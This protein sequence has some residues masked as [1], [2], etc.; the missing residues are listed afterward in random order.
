[1]AGIYLMLLGPAGALRKAL[2]LPGTI[3]DELLVCKWGRTE[4]IDMRMQKHQRYYGGLRGAALELVYFAPVDPR[5]QAAAEKDAKESLCSAG[6][7]MDFVKLHGETKREL[8]AL[9]EHNLKQLVGAHFRRIGV[10]YAGCLREL[11]LQIEK[12]V[13]I[14]QEKDKLKATHEDRIRELKAEKADLKAEQAEQNAKTA[15]RIRELNSVIEEL[16]LD[17]RMLLDMLAAARQQPLTSM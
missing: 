3:P 12:L 6:V 13:E 10:Q 2:Q 8:V 1:M 4:D 9:T 17:K 14:N 16:R 15:D 11:Q 5:E 7:H